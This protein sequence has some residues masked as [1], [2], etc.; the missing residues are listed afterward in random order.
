[1]GCGDSRIDGFNSRTAKDP[2]KRVL[3]K[4]NINTARRRSSTRS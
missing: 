3:Y 2:S 4:D 1:M